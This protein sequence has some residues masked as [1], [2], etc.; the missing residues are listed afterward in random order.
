[1]SGG[2]EIIFTVH[3]VNR[4]IYDVTQT[5][6]KDAHI[7]IWPSVAVTQRLPGRGTQREY[8]LKPLKHRIV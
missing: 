1:M 2:L 7:W 3:Q 4:L 6:G 8:S 5:V